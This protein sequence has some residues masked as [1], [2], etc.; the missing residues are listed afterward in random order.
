MFIR[1]A[2]AHDICAR[3]AYRGDSVGKAADAALAEVAR[4]GGNGGVIVL[5]ARGNA[6]LPFN[7]GGMYRGTIDADGKVSI[8]I[9]AE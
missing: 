3:M 8:A 2:V 1:S 6:A 4:L 9:Y 7:S 5:D